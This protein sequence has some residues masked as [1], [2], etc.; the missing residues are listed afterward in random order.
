MSQDIP[1]E[2]VFLALARLSRRVSTNTTV[3]TVTA[4][5]EGPLGKPPGNA[6]DPYINATG[7]MTLLL[8]LG[9]KADVHDPTRDED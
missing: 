5:W 1:E 8:K 2:S 7:S 4:L 9:R 3:A 6:T